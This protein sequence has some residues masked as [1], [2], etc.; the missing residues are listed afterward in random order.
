MAL[1][2]DIDEVVE[3]FSELCNA[4]TGYDRMCTALAYPFSQVSYCTWVPMN[5]L[6]SDSTDQLYEGSSAAVHVAPPVL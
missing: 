1:V 5:S 6:Q 2:Q 3:A 4:D